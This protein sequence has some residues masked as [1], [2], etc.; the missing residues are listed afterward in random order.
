M[1]AVV[2]L[3]AY[4]FLESSK[5]ICIPSSL[6]QH[7]RNRS[8]SPW[9]GPSRL[10]VRA[11]V[12]RPLG[13]SWPP[14]Y[15][16]IR[17]VAFRAVLATGRTCWSGKPCSLHVHCPVLSP[18]KRA[19]SRHDAFSQA[20][21]KSAPATGGVKKPHRYR[22]GTVVGGHER[23]QNMCRVAVGYMRSHPTHLQ[24]SSGSARTA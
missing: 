12:E 4:S 11:Q 16:L 18:D 19:L 5:V 7:P 3:L 22:P 20:A 6:Q 9:P 1:R 21:R 24:C 13:N 10:L 14:R 17:S 23:L 15:A 2:C 8:S